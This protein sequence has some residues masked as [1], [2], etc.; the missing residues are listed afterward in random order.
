M[1]R[2][3]DKLRES[4]CIVET[5]A[6]LEKYLASFRA[7]HFTFMVLIGGWGTGK[8]QLVKQSL[9][10]SACWIEG[11]ATAFGIYSLFYKYRDRH[12]VLDDVDAIST[13]RHAVSLLKSICRMEP[14]KV[15]AWNA[16][17]EFLEHSGLPTE[18]PTKSPVMII[19]NEWRALNMNAEALEDRALVVHFEPSPREIHERAG[20][21]FHDKEIYDWFGSQ[22]HR[23]KTHS[24]RSYVKAERLKA[25]GMPWKKIVVASSK[26]DEKETLANELLND[27]SFAGNEDRARA[28]AKRGGGS[29]G[30]F[31]F[32]RRKIL[33]LDVPP[34]P[35]RR[36]VGRPRKEPAP[37]PPTPAKAVGAKR[38]P[39]R[40][41]KVV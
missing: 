8:S 17:S 39:G 14:V 38:G 28:F 11:N 2:R 7:G 9:G 31:Y 35:P 18:F 37:P 15:V 21:W 19:C 27:N 20:T 22:L 25:C 30:T 32:Y 6:E 23:I 33:G 13:N 34:E 16:R 10:E 3:L 1:K 24:F 5:Y 36:P 40:P 4:L 29:R 12:V 26:K 41:R